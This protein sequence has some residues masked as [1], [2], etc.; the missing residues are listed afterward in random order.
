MIQNKR[1]FFTFEEP[2]VNLYKVRF[3]SPTCMDKSASEMYV[4]HFH[5]PKTKVKAHKWIIVYILYVLFIS[6]QTNSDAI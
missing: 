4:V 3:F 1:L 2:I 6:L 5:Y